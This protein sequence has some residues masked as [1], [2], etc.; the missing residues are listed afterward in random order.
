MDHL[1]AMQV[2]SA[3]AQ[4]GSLVGASRKLA[5]SPA[6][7]TRVIQELEEHLGTPLLIRTTRAINLTDTG[8]AYL[9][10]VDHILAA[11]RG[12]DAAARGEA[13]NPHG[14]LRLTAPRLFGRYYIAPIIREYVELYPE[15]HVEA[16]FRDNNSSIIDEG[17]DIAVRIGELKDS[18]M[19]ATKVGAV[20]LTVSGAPSY[21]ERRAAPTHPDELKDHEI[22][23]YEGPAFSPSA[24]C[25]DQGLEIPI[26]SRLKFNDIAACIRMAGL[27]FG[28][29]QT[30]SYQVG[31]KIQTVQLQSVLDDFS[32]KLRPINLVRANQYGKSAKLVAFLDLAKKRLR[33]DPIL[34]PNS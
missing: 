9:E 22:I 23:A 17:F 31:L 27:G 2:F 32:T 14:V 7:V 3:I 26:K 16:D 10:N 11:I 24:W 1:K 8:S 6:S 28:L 4:E 29:T 5:I 25:F 33:A 15:V 13:R 20:R 21:F 12:A 18:S 30:L 34:N 19:L